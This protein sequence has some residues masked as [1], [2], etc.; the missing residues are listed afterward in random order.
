MTRGWK[1]L[2]RLLGRRPPLRPAVMTVDQVRDIAQQNLATTGLWRPEISVQF[3]PSEADASR[4][5]WHVITNVPNRGAHA[6]LVIDDADQ[7]IVQ[8]WLVDR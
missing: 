7:R 8:R 4:G 3:R 6:H 5:V 2:G 1:I